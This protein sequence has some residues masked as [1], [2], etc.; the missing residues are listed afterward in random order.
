MRA[1]ILVVEDNPANIDLMTYLLEASGHEVLTARDGQEGLEMARSE[2]PALIVSDIQMPRMNGYDLAIALKADPVLALIPVL[3]VTAFAMVGDRDK[4]IDAG[5]DGYLSKPIEP[6]TFVREVEAF[7]SPDPAARSPAALAAAEP[8]RVPASGKR[9][10]VLDNDQT[11]LELAATALRYAGHVVDTA[12]DPQAAY[13]L[14]LAA[15]P[16]II[17]SDVCMPTSSGLEFLQKIK[18]HSELARIPFVFVSATA[19]DERTR[20]EALALGADAYL[21]RP[22][23]IEVLLDTVDNWLRRS[24]GRPA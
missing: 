12:V 3:A 14:A 18:A 13:A 19:T 9:V 7:L 2:R 11:N 23:E 24:D 8:V 22:I 10:L 20:Q 5:F 15:R 6:T 17:L 21:F 1:R 16:D 4:A